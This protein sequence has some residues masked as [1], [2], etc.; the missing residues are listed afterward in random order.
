MIAMTAKVPSLKFDTTFDPPTLEWLRADSLKPWRLQRVL[1][2]VAV[3]RIANEWNPNTFG[4]L[5]V[6]RRHDVNYLLDGQHRWMA[7]VREFGA[8]EQLLQCLV[9]IGLTDAQE[10][11]IFHSQG[12]LARRSISGIHDAHV[13]YEG[14]DPSMVALYDLMQEAGVTLVWQHGKQDNT[15]IAIATLKRLVSRNGPEHLSK[16]LNLLRESLGPT[17][18]A[19]NGHMLDGM[20]AFLLRYDGDFNRKEF[21]ARMRPLGV[22][23][24]EREGN[25]IA[26]LIGSGNDRNN[27]GRAFHALYNA[28]RRDHRLPAWEAN[29]V[30]PLTAER[31]T[32]QIQAVNSAKGGKM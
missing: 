10:T 29:V 25:R 26:A 8:P 9:Y 31:R 19:Y 6:S 18:H 30:S 5:I 7:V 20:S 11:E 21:I 24:V 27:I 22:D 23:L 28:R 14:G 32:A 4:H 1:N 13:L 16:V 17:Q 15:T 3:R 2:N 12:P